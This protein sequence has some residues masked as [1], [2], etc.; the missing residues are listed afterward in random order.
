MEEFF[1]IGEILYQKFL[2]DIYRHCDKLELTEISPAEKEKM[3]GEM[4]DF[5]GKVIRS[6]E[7]RQPLL[8]IG[9]HDRNS[10]KKLSRLVRERV[11]GDEFASSVVNYYVSKR[12][13]SRRDLDSYLTT[14]AIA[15]ATKGRKMDIG[16]LES[17]IIKAKPHLFRVASLLSPAV[18][19]HEKLLSRAPAKAESET[20]EYRGL[21]TSFM[22]YID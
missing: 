2:L 9:K 20:V 19:L 1:D 5:V 15:V 12:K 4:V 17:K 6:L 22:R 18:S 8:L 7:T 14:A 11:H 13:I 16:L 21:D 3:A 10:M